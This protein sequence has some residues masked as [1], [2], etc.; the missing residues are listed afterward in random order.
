MNKNI[1]IGYK[2]FDKNLQCRGFQYK[3]GE[4]Y[5]HTE[6]MKLCSK[7]FHFCKRL[8]SVFNYYPKNNETRVCEILA[9][10]IESKDDKS[11][12]CKITIIREISKEE[13][14]S[15]HSNSGHYNS[16]YSNSGHYNSGNYNS[17]YSNS[18]HY[19]SGNYNSGHCNSGYSNSGYSN[20]GHYNIGHYNSGYSNS[21]HYNSGYFNTTNQKVRLFNKDS[22]LEFTNEQI[23]KLK[24]IHYKIKPIIQWISTSNMSSQEQKD[25][26]EHKTTGGFLR[27]TNRND[28]NAWNNKEDKDFIQSLPGYNV[29]IFKEITGLD[30][31]E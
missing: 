13:L 19:N 17:G 25:Y 11:V 8:E 5:I 10:D 26:P 1:H 28:Y 24:N 12:T 2:A 22:S 30:W 31:K 3:V 29:D 6:A 7:G 27:K 15:G 14:N 20:S 23:Q 16:G 9:E 18:G 4:T 21:G